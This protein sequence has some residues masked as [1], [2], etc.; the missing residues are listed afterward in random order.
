[1]SV[2]VIIPARYGST[3][4]P[5][6]PLALICGKPMI[7][8]V[9]EAALKSKNAD[10][11]IVATDDSRI[12]DC[13]HNTDSLKPYIESSKLSVKITSPDHQ[14]GTDRLAEVVK[15]DPSIK[16][17][18]NFQGDEPL[19]PPEYLDVVV[20]PLLKNIAEMATL[21]SPMT[22]KKKFES[23]NDV[24]A[25]FDKDGFAIEFSRSPIPEN[26]LAQKPSG[27]VIAYHHHGIYSYTRKVLLKFSELPQSQ[28]EISERLEQLRAMDNGIKI[29]I[30][31]VPKATQAVDTADDIKKVEE[32]IL[33]R[34]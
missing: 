31:I 18:V 25:T 30:E 10:K 13:V 33:S 9:V 15:A 22:D 4:L 5:A 3:R 29:K 7:V 11:I 17:I 21:V 6:K 26:P 19:L 12:A 28:R 27:D 2:A 14:S 24:K 1:M 23:P 34:V 8:W 20:E 16:Y 32:A